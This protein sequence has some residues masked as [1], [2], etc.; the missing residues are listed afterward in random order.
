[1]NFLRVLLLPVD[2]MFSL[3]PES[4]NSLLISS[5]KMLRI[6][7]MLLIPSIL[8]TPRQGIILSSLPNIASNVFLF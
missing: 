4:E 3:K 1:M 2:A 7:V 8:L 6:C 5:L